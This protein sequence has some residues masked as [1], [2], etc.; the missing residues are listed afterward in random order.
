MLAFQ[1]HPAT[2][3]HMNVRAEFHGEDEVTLLDLK[4]TTKLPNIALDRASP[5]LRAAIFASEEGGDLLGDPG[6]M[7]HVKHPELGVLRWKG[8]FPAKFTLHF[9]AS[10][11]LVLD[12]AT[13]DKI[14][15]EP[16]EGG[17]CDF[18]FRLRYAPDEEVA[19]RL[20]M[21]LHHEVLTTLATGAAGKPEGE[22][23]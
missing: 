10:P 14:A 2:I 5:T 4:V 18:T 1:N 16:K 20:M 23:E 3:E 21:L 8:E 15:F 6:H 11:D 13:L 19:A 9:G 22:D 7:P 17:A 12:E